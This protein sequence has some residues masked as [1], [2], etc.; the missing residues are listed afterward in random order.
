[1]TASNTKV[2]VMVFTMSDGKEM[3]LSISDPVD[4]LL[5]GTVDAAAASWISNNVFLRDGAGA[6]ALKESY[7]KTTTISDLPEE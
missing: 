3:T 5:Q 1:M 2:L 4:D 7:I 6:T